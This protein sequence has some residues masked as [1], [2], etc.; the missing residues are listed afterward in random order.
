MHVPMPGRQAWIMFLTIGRLGLAAG[1]CAA[2]ILGQSPYVA[3][4]WLF[5]IIIGDIGDGV[6]ARHFDADNTRRRIAD[7][8]VD[9]VSIHGAMIALAVSVPGAA[10]LLLAVFLRDGVLISFNLW[11]F[12]HKR[13]I[14]TVGRVHKIGTML[15]AVLYGVALFPISGWSW[16]A[17]AAISTVLWFL[18]L[19]YLRAGWMIPVHPRGNPVVRYRTRGLEALRGKVPRVGIPGL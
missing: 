12:I 8:V 19:D 3:I 18:L 2:V 10:W 4:A 13:A 6:I 15:Y 9:R 5:A 1:L 17:A 7:A 16:A 11:V 14:V